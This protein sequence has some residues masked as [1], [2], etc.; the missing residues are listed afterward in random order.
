M[1]VASHIC[2]AVPHIK[3]LE[4]VVAVTP[5]HSLPSQVLERFQNDVGYIQPPPPGC[6]REMFKLMVLCW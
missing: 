1:N 2:T 6:P 3:A 5:S 4:V